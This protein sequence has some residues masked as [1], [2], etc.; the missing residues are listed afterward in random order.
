MLAETKFTPPLK[1]KEDPDVP[2]TDKRRR[3]SSNLKQ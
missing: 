1:E 3:N 2:N